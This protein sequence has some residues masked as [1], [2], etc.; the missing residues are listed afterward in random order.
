MYKRCTN[1]NIYL[2]ICVNTVKRLRNEIEEKKK[3]ASDPKP[4]GT[5]KKLSHAQMLDGAHAKNTNYTVNRSGG[6]IK[7]R[8][9]DFLGRFLSF[10]SYIV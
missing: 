10:L 6:A 5:A 9:E 8:E 7:L 3:K 1:K 2:N 4:K